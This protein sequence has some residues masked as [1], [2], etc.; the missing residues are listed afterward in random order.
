[1]PIS[2]A[3]ALGVHEQAL[4]IRSRRAEL[5]ASNLAHADTPHYKARDID[6]KTALEAAHS[7]QRVTLERTHGSHMGAHAQGPGGEPLYRI[8]DHP[9]L[10]GNTVDAQVE[11]VAFTENAV[12]YQATLSLLSGRFR[13]LRNAIRGE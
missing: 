11:Q 10:D 13:G 4:M 6:F 5:L 3:K 1:M 2:F 8:P 7:S 12:Y 9:S